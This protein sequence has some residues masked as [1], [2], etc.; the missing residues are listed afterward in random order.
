M[1]DRAGGLKGYQGYG[2]TTFVRVLSGVAIPARRY[3]RS[4]C[5]LSR[6]G[7]G[8]NTSMTLPFGYLPKKETAV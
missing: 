3:A 7:M 5:V 8:K 6:N 1:G 4:P 2:S